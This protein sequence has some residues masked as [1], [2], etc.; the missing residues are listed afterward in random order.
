MGVYQA[1]PSRTAFPLTK[2][3]A[4]GSRKH[5]AHRAQPDF[6]R[7]LPPTVSNGKG[8]KQSMNGGEADTRVEPGLEPW[9]RD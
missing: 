7:V 5:S 8:T 6:A 1:P 9:L 4:Q 2:L 3:C